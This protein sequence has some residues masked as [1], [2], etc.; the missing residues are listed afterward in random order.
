MKFWRAMKDRLH[1]LVTRSKTRR[2]YGRLLVHLPALV[3]IG[4][5]LLMVLFYTRRFGIDDS[6]ITYRYANILNGNAGL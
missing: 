2:R 1:G 5:L 3:V 6:F 4:A